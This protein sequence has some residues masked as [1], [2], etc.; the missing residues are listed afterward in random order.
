MSLGI[1][2]SKFYKVPPVKQN[3]RHCNALN[4]FSKAGEFDY[5]AML[6]FPI[7]FYIRKL[8]KKQTS[9]LSAAYDLEYS[10]Q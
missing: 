1:A 5:S 3:K 7:I 8:K 9:T 2:D 10:I 6:E 4:F